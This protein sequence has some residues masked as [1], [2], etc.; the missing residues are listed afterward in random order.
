VARVVDQIREDRIDNEIVVDCYD[1]YEAAMGWL[2]YL[3]ESLPFPFGA[4]YHPEDEEV[5]RVMVLAIESDDEALG[6]GSIEF[7]AEIDDG[8][9]CWVS[10]EEITPFKSHVLGLRAVEDWRYWLARGQA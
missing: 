2:T 6:Q 3:Q 5:R 4:M 10:L 8:G 9:G 1:E 7:L